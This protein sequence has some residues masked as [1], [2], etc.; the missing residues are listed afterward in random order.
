MK[1]NLSYL[2]EWSGGDREKVKEMI[3]IFKNQVEEFMRDM[4][5]FL[6]RKDYM[7][8]GKLAHKA[9]SSISIMGLDD[10]SK[11]MKVLEDLAKSG[12]EAEKYPVLVDR[13]KNE[14]RKAVE[15][16]DEA[17]QNLESFL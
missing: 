14:T 3:D 6:N 8:L 9:K 7:A 2:R 11:D 17:M 1:V 5:E 10:L 12:E 4:D 15:E 13:F 16:L